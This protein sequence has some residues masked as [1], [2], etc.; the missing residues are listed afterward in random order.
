MVMAVKANKG[1]PGIDGETFEEIEERE[2]GAERYREEIA[3]EL[4][5]KD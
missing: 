5:R 3:G 1:A 4:K 2:G